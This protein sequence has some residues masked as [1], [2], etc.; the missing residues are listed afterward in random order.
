VAASKNLKKV[1]FQ[2]EAE[3]KHLVEKSFH[4]APGLSRAVRTQPMSSQAVEE[5]IT[6]AHDSNHRL[7]KLIKHVDEY[8]ASSTAMFSERECQLRALKTHYRQRLAKQYAE[9]REPAA[10]ART[11]SSQEQALAFNLEKQ[12][13]ARVHEGQSQMKFMTISQV[14]YHEQRAPRIEHRLPAREVQARGKARRDLR[15]QRALVQLA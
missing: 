12:N 6:Q 5:S 2:V 13:A 10:I 15:G 1:L 14:K 7:A 4:V 11:A 9:T 3:H 8:T